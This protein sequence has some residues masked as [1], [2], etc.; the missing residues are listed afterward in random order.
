MLGSAPV[1][2]VR[3]SSRRLMP[4]C[5][6]ACAGLLSARVAL[7]DEPTE[8]QDLADLSS[9]SVGSLLG[10]PPGTPWH[11]QLQ[12]RL[13]EKAWATVYD[14]DL[15]DTPASTIQSLAS[16]GKVVHC[17]FSAGSAENWRPDYSKFPSAG[18]G[19]NMD[20]WPGEKWVDVRSAGVRAVLLARM[21]LAKSK[22]CAGIDPDNVD[23]Y[24]HPT[25]FPLKQSDSIEFIKWLAAEGHKRGLTVGLKNGLEILAQVG[26]AV[27]WAIN[28]QCVEFNECTAYRSFL[29]AG[30]P[31]FHVEYSGTLSK[32]CSKTK[33][34]NISTVKAPLAL[35]GPAEKCP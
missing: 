6:L 30:K 34:L 5:L 18:L 26:A 8:T 33:P 28:E 2:L 13:Q 29:A 20:G 10:V 25:G 3:L 12:G 11:L 7:A 4:A 31:V 16:R 15:Y 14:I 22:G 35:N 21:D 9:S 32:I 17:Y 1:A 27:D 24:A 19:K 23:G